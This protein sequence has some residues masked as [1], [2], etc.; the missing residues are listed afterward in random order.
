[1]KTNPPSLKRF[2]QWFCGFIALIGLFYVV[3]KVFT[4]TGKD[5]GALFSL[6]YGNFN[7][8]DEGLAGVDINKLIWNIEN[9]TKIN[10]LGILRI[11]TPSLTTSRINRALVDNRNKSCSR[12]LILFCLRNS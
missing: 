11:L 7:A 12:F 9:M 3:P 10:Q 5:A 2:A 1:M 8:D 4:K 6:I